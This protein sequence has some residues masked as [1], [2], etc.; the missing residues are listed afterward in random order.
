M[1]VE[2]EVKI[3]LVGEYYEVM[4][5]ASSLL[6]GGKDV[7]FTTKEIAEAEEEL[8]RAIKEE[9]KQSR[10][11]PTV[12]MS[13]EP[14]TEVIPIKV[15]LDIGDGPDISRLEFKRRLGYIENDI[16][17]YNLIKKCVYKMSPGSVGRSALIVGMCI[18]FECIRGN[19]IPTL[20]KYLNKSRASIYVGK[21]SYVDKFRGGDV[22]RDV[23]KEL[24]SRLS[25]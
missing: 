18:E 17:R 16:D 22:W 13:S 25:K 12:I 6:S 15:G 8:K 24:S 23:I 20:A 5:R 2:V 1:Q 14:K 9:S 3:K 19:T 4:D 11:R 7:G 10:S 21:K